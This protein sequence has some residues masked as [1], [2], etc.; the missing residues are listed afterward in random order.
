[1][2]EGAY[3]GDKFF[4]QAMVPVASR[5]YSSIVVITTPK[6]ENNYVSRLV[7]VQEKDREL[8]NVL[9]IGGP[10]DE[11][12]KTDKP[13]AC[14]H[15][16]L[17][18]NKSQKRLA[19][20]AKHLYRGRQD[21]FERENFAIITSAGN[22]SFGALAIKQL[23]D[24]QPV[25]L[26]APPRFIYMFIDPSGGGESDVGICVHYYD[27]G[28]VVSGILFFPSFICFFSC[29]SVLL[30]LSSPPSFPDITSSWTTCGRASARRYGPR[31]RN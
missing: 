3:Q 9:T 7:E 16:D 18:P 20:F 30:S 26:R 17:P 27:Q 10:C 23:F 24:A 11:C 25:P 2:D 28:M 1:L 22:K 31:P 13:G 19:R 6:T 14:S 12:A 4:Y 8:I 5:N 15:Q 21:A 29:F